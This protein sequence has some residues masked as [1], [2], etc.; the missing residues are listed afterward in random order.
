MVGSVAALLPRKCLYIKQEN[1]P[2]EI[3]KFFRLPAESY[4]EASRFIW[5]ASKTYKECLQAVGPTV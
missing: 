1:T 4:P 5:K 2:L 3:T